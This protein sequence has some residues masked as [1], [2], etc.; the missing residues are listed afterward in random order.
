M[1]DTK[2]EFSLPQEEVK[3]LDYWKRERV[4]ER[5]IEQRKGR[6]EF[7]F[8][9]GPPGANGQ[10]HLG[11]VLARVYKDAVCR[12]KTMAGF[13]VL[14]KAGWDTHGLP[15]ELQVEKE[16]GLK[17]KKEIEQYGISRFNERA[18][19]TVWR[20]KEEWERLTDRIGFWVDMK[21]PYITYEPRYIEALWKIFAAIAKKKLLYKDFK[22]VPYCPRC[23][24]ALSSHE[25]ALGYQN[26]TDTAVFVKFKLREGQ[27][28]RTADGED[29]YFPPDSFVLS[30]TTTPWT[31]PGNVALAVGKEIRYAVV[32]NGTEHYVVG[33]ELV[34][35][36]GINDDVVAVAR[37]ASLVGMQYEPLFYVPALR[38]K[39]AHRIYT[40]DFVSTKEGTGV[41]HTAVMYGEDD[42]RLGNEIGLPKRH[43]V[44]EDGKFV[45]DFRAG[46]K[47]LNVR[48]R[49][50]EQ[51]IFDY[52]REKN[53]LLRTHDYAHEYPFCWRC[54]SALLYYATSS[55]F[56][57][58]SKIRKRLQS[59]NEQI[60]WVPGHIKHG[61]FGEW[62]REAKDWAISRE[63]Y[64]GTPLPIWQCGKCKR[65]HAVGSLVDLDRLA[66]R[67]PNTY[68]FLRHGEAVSNREGFVSS[69]PEVRENPLTARGR[70]AIER[71]LV[72][73][74]KEKIDFIFSSDMQRTKESA[75]I[76]ASGLG[77]RVTYDE[78]L[79]EHRTGALNGKSREEWVAQ[80]P[81]YES[82]Y[83]VRPEGGESLRDVSERMA[84]FL[85]ALDSRHSGKRM[86]IVSHGNPITAAIS[87]YE[88]YQEREIDAVEK[89]YGTHR[90]GCLVKTSGHRWPRNDQ[91]EVDLHRPYVDALKLRCSSCQD[92]LRRV[93]EVADVWFDSG[94]MPFAQFG[95]KPAKY[96]ADFITEGIDQTRGWFYTLHAVGTLMGKGPAYKNVI[97]LGHVLDEKGEKMSKSK[98]N[99]VDP[100][101][102]VGQY[103]ADAL[104]WYL[105]AASP[106][107][108]PKRF[109]VGDVGDRMRRTFLTCWNVLQ[110]Y[111]IYESDIPVGNR[112]RK[113][114]DLDRWMYS[115][116]A[117]TVRDARG[118]F[119]SYDLTAAARAIDTC[120]DDLSRWWLRRSRQRFQQP[121]DLEDFSRARATLSC[122]LET[123]ALLMSPLAPF[124]AEIIWRGLGRNG[125]IHL[126]DFPEPDKS[127][128]D[129][130]L[131][132]AM[133][134][135]RNIAALAL[136]ERAKAG[137]K[138][139]Q[140]IA[141]LSVKNQ[142]S[143]MKEYLELQQLV[144]G[145][146]NAKRM[147]FDDGI[148]DE[149]EIDPKLTSVLKEEG[150]VR[151]L[152][153]NVQALRRDAGMEPQQR[154]SLRVRSDRTLETVVAK[155]K[156]EIQ[157]SVNAKDIA[158]GNR[159]E[160]EAEREFLA[161]GRVVWIG[162][163]RGDR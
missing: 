56:I 131:E 64:W 117:E 72:R 151:E 14:R 135:T 50:T 67:P 37:G 123:I 138:V 10:P 25:V 30:W 119:D 94:A 86:L 55:W 6:K 8:Y 51:R 127:V 141:S 29:F 68:Y 77:K 9:E 100:W 34:P 7:V 107:G 76:I 130:A 5:S 145:E 69:W 99:V 156:R 114:G 90:T 95:G 140:P 149:V 54:G 45:A 65:D 17:S 73:L 83:R 160:S 133:E 23:G 120:I 28:V 52:L 18:R 41:V 81:D 38:H 20:Y 134:E 61:R 106:A 71:V 13:Y 46:L 47:G 137:L 153:R 162:V 39:K 15:V 58:V 113:F 121:D 89:K 4:F 88:G 3:I 33:E 12:Y 109:S 87:A 93:P 74:K 139:R 92:V 78:R 1:S 24:T 147:T 2:D 159:S 148:T 155:W 53:L 11:H 98:G 142:K 143:S 97:S 40:A 124:F 66:A 82:Q 108:E 115:R 43:T 161:D 16:L 57:A 60:N 126:A 146:V 26:V 75:H 136:A 63:R 163:S 36:L 102:I 104:R 129:S 128:I 62:I 79:R 112:A 154:V 150:F 144:L 35:T 19:E 152:T 96:P 111:K 59:N 125:S 80:F 118:A 27:K 132:E 32:R 105:F 48:D 84:S 44:S 116:L 101:E 110:F 42:F 91:G 22:V 49:E 21:D 158:V 85:R 122:A 70:K 31:L 103:G 157:K